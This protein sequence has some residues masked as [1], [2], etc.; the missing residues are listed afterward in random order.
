MQISEFNILLTSLH[1][2]PAGCILIYSERKSNILFCRSQ[3]K[4]TNSTCTPA[5]Q[6]EICVQLSSSKLPLGRLLGLQDTGNLPELDATRLPIDG[7]VG[8]EGCSTLL[9]NPVCYSSS[10]MGLGVKLEY[11]RISMPRPIWIGRKGQKS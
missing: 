8:R 11:M 10:N 6:A 4:N 1:Q 5:Q 9:T 7:Q 2:T 3:K